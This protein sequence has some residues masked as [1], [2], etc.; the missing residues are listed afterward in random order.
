MTK[1]NGVDRHNSSFTQIAP[2]I[3]IGILIVYAILDV[4]REEVLQLDWSTKLEVNFWEF[5][6]DDIVRAG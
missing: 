2:P 4:V 5:S 3:L 6:V 1:L